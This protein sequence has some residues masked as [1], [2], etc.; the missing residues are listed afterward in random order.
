M[1]H[2]TLGAS[3]AHRWAYCPGSV[4]ASA[5][6]PNTSSPFA[7]E[8][9][10]A[11]EMAEEVLGSIWPVPKLNNFENQEMAD[12]VSVYTQY[13]ERLSNGADLTMIEQRVDYSDWVLGG[14]GTADAIVLRGDTLHVVDLKYGMGVQVY[15][16]NNPQGMLYALGAYNEI[17]HAA[18]IKRVVITIVQPRLDHISEWEISIPDLLKWAEWISQRAEATAAPDA[19]RIAGESQCKFCLAKHNCGALLK[20]TTDAMLT[21]FDNLDNLPAPDTLTEEQVGAALAAKGLI[22]G[23][24][25]AVQA[26]VVERL[27]N[28]QG[29]PGFKLVA[30]RSSRSWI[31]EEE[32]RKDLIKMMGIAKALTEPKLISPPQAEK[33]LGSKRKAD[34]QF[35][36]AKAEGKPTLAPD[37]DKRPAVNVQLSDFD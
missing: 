8:G 26:H 15:A 27:E 6:L 3:S 11:H 18:D 28:G 37:S 21:E 4:A 2:A 1:K 24:L 30:G 9:T 35:M 16:E 31:D 12:Y 7:E 17:R 32:A 20:H 33:V 23:W 25:N 14:F 5:D 36:I 13:V 29:F 34:I 10:A 22:E 19:P